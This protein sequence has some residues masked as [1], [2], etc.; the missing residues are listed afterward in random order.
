MVC[1][2]SVDEIEIYSRSSLSL[3]L[4][5]TCTFLWTAL[6]SSYFLSTVGP[7]VFPTVGWLQDSSLTMVS[8]CFMDVCAKVLY[9][10]VI[11]D[12]HDAVFDQGKR[13]E[14]RLEELRQM[15]AVVWDNS[16]DVIGI[17]VRSVNGTV[18][19]VSATCIRCL[20]TALLFILKYVV[21]YKPRM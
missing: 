4:L 20:P 16:S 12:V 7:M 2:T 14:R 5:C 18:T 9:M 3:K 6:V 8:E 15:M 13:A 11:V 21:P 10:S 19:T 17:S 1:G